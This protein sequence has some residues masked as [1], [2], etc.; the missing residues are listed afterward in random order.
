MKK[1][2]Y[3]NIIFFIYII[4]F[5][6][7]STKTQYVAENKQVK[8]TEY[9]KAP[10]IVKKN[11]KTKENV[12]KVN[13]EVKIEND[14][15]KII[16]EIVPKVYTNIAIVFPS[17]VIGKYAI[18]ATNTVMSYLLYKNNNFNLQVFDTIDENESSIRNIF[19]KIS[20]KNITKVLVLLTQDGAKH[21]SK[22]EDINLFDL[23][24]PLIHKNDLDLKITSAVY[25][26]ID[27]SQQFDNLLNYSNKKLVN[28]YDNSILGRNLSA[29]L[30]N[31]VNKFL[32]QKE[33]NNDN[34]LYKRFLTKKNKIL[35]NSTLFIN[36]PIVKSSIILSQIH[37]NDIYVH[38]A[39][40][41]QLNYTP[42]LLSLTQVQDRKNMIIASSISHTN[43]TIE[44]YNFL[45]NSDIVYNWVNYSTTIGVEYLISKSV[46]SF[47]SIELKNNQILYPVKLFYT[48]K[49]AF[50]KY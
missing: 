16:A 18:D 47:N 43:Q 49:Y 4:S 39:L 45:L 44:E 3:I 10:I 19:N 20:N 12:V 34:G 38:K 2:L 46:K 6:G 24:L 23:Y 25:G 9:I 14:A 27:Y 13:T 8:K 15:N 28:F 33:I 42:L 48:S 7:C 26:S 22:I 35:M 5:V 40:S 30:N 1:I 50:K 31:K 41:T 17:K 37:A 32:Y 21:L 11:L 36:M 29:N